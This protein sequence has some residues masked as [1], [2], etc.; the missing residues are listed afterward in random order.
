MFSFMNNVIRRVIVLGFPV[1]FVAIEFLLRTALE[2]L[3]IKAEP[4]E[5]IPA[6]L[7][8]S[9]IGQLFSVVVIRD[10]AKSLSKNIRQQ[11]KQSGLTVSSQAD[12]FVATL[13]WIAMLLLTVVWASLIYHSLTR[14]SDQDAL[15][16]GLNPLYIGIGTYF[17]CMVL[18]EAKEW[19]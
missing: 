14:R 3:H 16:W 17:A 18:A 15:L 7:A 9:G 2:Q 10:K 13:G 5:F 8:A 6:T 11:L 4:H 12:K 19:V 1:V